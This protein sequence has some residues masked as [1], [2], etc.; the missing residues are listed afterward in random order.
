MK[1]VNDKD[2]K[3][4]ITPDEI[5]EELK[6]INEIYDQDVVLVTKAR[7]AE[8]EDLETKDD[9]GL[10]NR[11]RKFL[12]VHDAKNGNVK[13]TCLAMNMNRS[14]YHVWVRDNQYFA[15]RCEEIR[16]GLIDEAESALRTQ[17]R[18]GNI[19][20]IIF[21]L[22]TQAKH[23]GYVEKQEVTHGGRIDSGPSPEVDALMTR[24]EKNLLGDGLV[25]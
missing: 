6:R 19:A 5:N 8:L 10:T 7:Q 9:N 15:D 14:T 18:E 21:F 1:I 11:Q 2:T 3:T 4:S 24:I 16:E 23:R 13:N 20:A 22:K 17:I 12:K 25:N